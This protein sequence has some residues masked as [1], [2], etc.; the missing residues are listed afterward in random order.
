MHPDMV[1]MRH[2][3]SGA[4][5]FLARHWQRLGDGSPLEDFA[6]QVAAELDSHR[7]LLPPLLAQVGPEFRLA[8]WLVGYRDIH[9]VTGPPVFH[10]RNRA[11]GHYSFLDAAH[12]GKEG[13]GP[14]SMVHTFFEYL[15]PEEHFAVHPEFYSERNGR[16]V[17]S[18]FPPASMPTTE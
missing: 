9:G 8:D 17:I 16:R 11:N 5:H 18:D 10:A 4:P 2:A 6:V 13:Y 12:G 15:P 7:A 3:S 14:P 1:I